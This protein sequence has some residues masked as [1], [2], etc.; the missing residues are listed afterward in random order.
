MASPEGRSSDVGILIVGATG[1]VGRAL[2]ERLVGEGHRVRA[3]VRAV[4]RVPREPPAGAEW[5]VGD[6]LEPATLT[7]ALRGIQTVYYLAH[8]MGSSDRTGSFAVRDRTAATN[9][10][11][12]AGEA[13]VERIVYVG[14]LGDEAPG[15]SPHLESRREVARIL[16]SGRPRLTTFRAAIVVGAGGASFEMLVQLV[17]RL[18]A[19]LCPRWIRTRCQPIA[20]GDLVTYLVRSL[21]EP[22]TIGRSFDV[23]GPDVLPYY[24]LL[25]RVGDR[26]GRRSRLVILPWLTPGL[27]AHWVGFI[28]DVPAN[29]ARFLVEGMATEV[30]CHENEI[31]RWIPLRLLSFD[32]ALDRALTHRPLRPL[33]LRQAL[34]RGFGTKPL[35]V[36]TVDLTRLR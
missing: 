16:A 36:A 13:G 23:G 35:H 2:T 32:E 25:N 5:V 10:V 7:P 19:M 29:V 14:G 1:F 33:G 18:P 8:A 30:V 12:A 28:T 9:L 17:E 27:S 4:G 6:L 3:L 34:A 24:D 15:R 31:R 26:L 20:V 22:Q 11:R 21:A